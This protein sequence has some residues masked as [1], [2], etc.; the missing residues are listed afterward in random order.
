MLTTAKNT[1]ETTYEYDEQNRVIK[2]T[3]VETGDVIAPTITTTCGDDDDEIETGIELE[4]A[5]EL[6]PLE[7]FLTAAAGAVIGNLLYRA[8]RKA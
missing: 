1:T 6:S 7:V 3:V 5:V 4:S 2:R 8:I